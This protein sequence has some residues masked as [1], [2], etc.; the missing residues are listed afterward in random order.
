M[1]LTTGNHTIE[2]GTTP[3][4]QLFELHKIGNRTG[5]MR[6][7]TSAE[8]F[9][10]WIIADEV[11]EYITRETRER[12]IKAIKPFWTI[13]KGDNVRGSFNEELYKK[14]IAAKKANGTLYR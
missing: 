4:G 10:R 14:V 12:Y 11:T 2:Y 13:C 6:V 9:L 3:K 7:T 5:I 8:L 1:Q